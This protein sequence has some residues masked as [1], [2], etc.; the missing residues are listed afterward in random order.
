MKKE[1]IYQ[2]KSDVARE[3]IVAKFLEAEWPNF[4]LNRTPPFH[5]TD[6]HV[7]QWTSNGTL[8]YL[9]DLEI[10]WFNHRSTRL[11]M[12]NFRK[13]QNLMLLPPSRVGIN[14]HLAFRFDD[15]LLVIP[16][17]LLADQRPFWFTRQDTGERDLVVGVDKLNICSTTNTHFWFD[18]ALTFNPDTYWKGVVNE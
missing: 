7:S 1:P 4:V 5:V 8:Q 17:Y 15:G 13:L 18:V 2:T 12:F 10:K 9:F 14:H 3:Q 6:Y 16:A 11:A